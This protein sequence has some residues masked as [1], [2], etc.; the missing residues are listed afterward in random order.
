MKKRNV[1]KQVKLPLELHADKR[2]KIADVFY[3]EN[4]HHVAI[5]SSKK[6]ALRGDHYHAQ[7]VQHMLITR[8]ALEYWYKP[9]GSAQAAKC[10]VLKV[11]DLVTTPAREIHALRI[12]ENNEFVVFTT[13]KRGGKDYESDTFRMQPSIIPT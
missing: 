13:G 1:W 8:G 2:G 11:G 5:I 3:R 12:I 9:L 10:Q 7:T 6:G 4:I